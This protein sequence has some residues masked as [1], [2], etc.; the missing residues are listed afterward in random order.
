MCAV[1][2]LHF[3]LFAL[4][5]LVPHHDLC[6]AAI[7]GPTCLSNRF[8]L[9]KRIRCFEL[10]PGF[11][12]AGSGQVYD[13]NLGIHHAPANVLEHTVNIY[14][15]RYLHRVVENLYKAG[16]H[17]YVCGRIACLRQ[18]LGRISDV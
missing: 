6:R 14:V 2:V 12:E 5:E 9:A 4:E 17:A 1:S 18:M 15:G 10:L 16:R 8:Q 11:V 13:R 3:S 7:V